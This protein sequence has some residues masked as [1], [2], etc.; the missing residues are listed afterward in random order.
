MATTGTCTKVNDSF[1]MQVVTLAAITGTE[2]QVFTLG[3]AMYSSYQATGTFDSAT[4]Q[5]QGSNDNTNWSSIG[6]TFTSAASNSLTPS[7]V[8][9]KYYRLST[10]GGGG[11]QSIAVV[12]VAT[13]PR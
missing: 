1:G 11:S 12:V 3:T 2:S 4:C 13:I 7:Q 9:Y 10:S 8:F 6:S 5:W